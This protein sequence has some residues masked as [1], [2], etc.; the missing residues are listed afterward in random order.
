M[1]RTRFLLATALWLLFVAAPVSAF[2]LTAVPADHVG[3]SD[4]TWTQSTDGLR[5]PLA[6]LPE[7]LGFKF[8]LALTVFES[9]D[10]FG[11]ARL[12]SRVAA[13][14]SGRLEPAL[15]YHPSGQ[16]SDLVSQIAWYRRTFGSPPSALSYRRGFDSAK[17]F[18][19]SYVLGARNSTWG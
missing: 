16:E 13:Y 3:G 19:P 6:F 8:D 12:S 1:G 18:V 4:A 11:R 17:V 5:M 2:A 15:Y 9:P 14:R 10:T 7:L